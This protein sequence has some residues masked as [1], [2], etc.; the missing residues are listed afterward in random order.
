MDRV[1]TRTD[2]EKFFMRV[3]GKTE[4]PKYTVENV[5]LLP[6]LGQ[7]AWIIY[8]TATWNAGEPYERGYPGNSVVCQKGPES[9]PYLMFSV[10][11]ELPVGLATPAEEDAAIERCGVEE[12]E[13][14]VA[15]LRKQGQ[16]DA[17]TST[18]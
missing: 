12:A 7:P 15:R 11:D 3:F 14:Y 5:A 18:Y 17:S 16:S 1:F 2:V 8:H 6:G 13:K 4:T 9:A 10:E